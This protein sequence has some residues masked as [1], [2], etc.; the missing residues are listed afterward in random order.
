M[1]YAI[2][3]G[4]RKKVKI[5]YSSVDGEF[6][7]RQMQTG[8]I[9]RLRLMTECWGTRNLEKRIHEHLRMDKVVGEW[10]D[11]SPRTEELLKGMAMGPEGAYLVITGGSIEGYITDAESQKI[12]RKMSSEGLLEYRGMLTGNRR[13]HAALNWGR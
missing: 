3:P 2:R 6:R 10:F 13:I 1:I 4:E 8:S 9:D 5:G 12:R 7:L 11:L